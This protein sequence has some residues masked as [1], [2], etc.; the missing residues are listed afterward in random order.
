MQKIHGFNFR[1]RIN[2]ES[3]EEEPITWS[4]ADSVGV[5][6]PHYDPI[7]ITADVG[8]WNMERILVDEG[9]AASVI[10]SNGYGI[11]RA[12]V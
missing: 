11:G 3:W 5:L 6:M 8:L 12:H 1:D 4:A 7:M 2:T 9:S 10:F